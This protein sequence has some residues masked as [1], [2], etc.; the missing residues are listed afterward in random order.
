MQVRTVSCC[1]LPDFQELVLLVFTKRLVS[2]C[3]RTC[4]SLRLL[5]SWPAKV[6]ALSLHAPDSC[7]HILLCMQAGSVAY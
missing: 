7:S 3:S 5:Y 6:Q 1:L 2:I 4:L